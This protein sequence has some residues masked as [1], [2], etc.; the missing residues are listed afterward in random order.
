MGS[1]Y[2]RCTFKHTR[3]ERKIEKALL[4][5]L[6]QYITQY[7]TTTKITDTET[8][9][10]TESINNRIIAIKQ[11]MANSVKSFNKG[12]MTEAEH[13]KEYSELEAELN[14]LEARLQPHTERDLSV[15]ED[16][17]NSDWKELYNALNKENKR[18]FWRKYIKRIK[19]ND[20]GVVCDVLFF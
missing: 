8:D 3:S 17:L 19:L 15:Y 11:E 14:T 7:I 6:D 4:N 20:D 9:T 16:L 12:R 1:V 5:C 18:A 2:H 13:D 10:E